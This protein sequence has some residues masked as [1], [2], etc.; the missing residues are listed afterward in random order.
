MS[1]PSD[2][3]GMTAVWEAWAKW[4]SLLR[5]FPSLQLAP[6]TLQQPILPWTFA[7][8]VVNETNSRNPEAEHAILSQESYGTQLGRLSD[9]LEYLIKQLASQHQINARDDC[10]ADFLSMKQRID[11]IKSSMK[12]PT[13]ERILRDL[14]SLKRR[15]APKFEECLSRVVELA[16][17]G[18]MAAPALRTKKSRQ[19][20]R[21]GA[22]PLETTHQSLASSGGDVTSA[23]KASSA[24]EP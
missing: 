11:S 19:R 20:A 6:E 22:P 18:A 2:K 23:T 7:G 9:A 21:A 12:S 5:D 1:I 24:Q 16:E 10:I 17:K 14:E 8:L 3:T 4:L 13:P 15:D